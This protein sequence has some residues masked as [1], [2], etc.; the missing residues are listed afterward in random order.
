MNSLTDGFEPSAQH[1]AYNFIKEEILSLRLRPNSHLNAIG[2]A[3]QLEVSR[4]PIREA[5]GRLEQDGLVARE[6]NTNTGFRVRAIT[7]KEIIDVYKVREALEVAAALEALPN[8]TLD[9]LRE[10]DATLAES[11][12]LL[13]RA[14][15]AEFI[16]VNRKFHALLVTASGNGMF[17][18][19]MAP[20]SDRVRLVGA[21][22]IQLHA[23]RQREVLDENLAI[24]EALRIGDPVR[25]EE[26][27][28]AHV[29][30]AREH[31]ANLLSRDHDRL[32]FGGRD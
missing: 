12:G 30:R 1:A 24:L 22:L 23:P 2:L 4:T 5:L 8:L 27:V 26:S 18:I 19:I 3:A 13:D 21:M 29:R 10:L 15:Y 14:K 20:I 17:K 6:A 31:A 25:V 16:L 7:L 32:Y 9:V 11:E 28:R